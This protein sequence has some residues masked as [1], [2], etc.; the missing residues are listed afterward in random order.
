MIPSSIFRMLIN[1]RQAV[2]QKNLIHL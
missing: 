1:F 2:Y